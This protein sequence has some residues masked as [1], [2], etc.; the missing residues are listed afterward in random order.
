MKILLT[1]DAFAPIVNGVV[2]SVMT[3]YT[4]LKLR[5]H[6]VRILALAHE[7]C[8]RQEGDVYMIRS[9]SVNIYPDARA[10]VN[11]KSR[12]VS[13]IIKWGPDIIHSQTEFCSF[14]FARKIAKKLDIPIIHTYHTLYQDYTSYFTKH[15]NL[16]KKAVIIFSRRILKT[17]DTVVVPT[18]KTKGI[19]EAYHIEPPIEVIPNGI[20]FT[21]FKKTLTQEEKNA[22]QGTL[23]IPRGHKVIVTVGRVGKEKNLDE[24]MLNM[25]ALIEQRKNISL[26]IVG[27]GPYRLELEKMAEQLGI[28]DSVVF[29]GMID[30]MEIYKYYKLGDIFVSGSTSETQ[31][32]TYI[33]A[34]INE[35]P[36]VCRKDDC[37]KALL[38]EGYN[39]YTYETSEEF[40]HIINDL[41]DHPDKYNEIKAH[42]AESVQAYSSEI[43]GKRIEALYEKVIAN[44]E[45]G[46]VEQ[47]DDN[48]TAIVS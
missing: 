34:L 29:A 17:V 38:K 11:Y 16:G 39:G 15:E 21:R 33:E 2:T 41:L 46:Y 6:D 13:E 1:T 7:G 12:M 23:N 44:K 14:L 26:V 9:F 42:T 5:G 25:K 40:I 18:N 28:R 20:D 36:I 31:G 48:H 3:L 10:T 30:Q 22:L 24:V 19:L 47:H 43:F 8:S 35:V 27:N 37:L 4:Q 32:L 45:Q